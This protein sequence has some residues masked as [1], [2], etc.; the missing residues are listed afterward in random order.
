MSTVPLG[1]K[2]FFAAVGALALWVAV[3]GLLLPGQVTEALPWPVPPL[4]ARFLGSMY[5]SGA[6]FMVGALLARTWPTVRVIV[7]MISVWT[8]ALAIVSLV[9]LA[10]FDFGR[11][12]T[13]VWFAAYLVYPLIAAWIA[14]R[15]RG[16]HE[17]S[18]GAA[19]P[20]LLRGYLLAQGGVLVLLALGLF[21]FPDAAAGAW[22]W[23]ITPL[24]A[25]IYGAPFLSYG[26]GSLCA[27]RQ[28]TRPEVRLFLVG[29]LVFAAG[30]Q[31][32][33]GLHRALFSSTSPA[34]WIWFVG[35]A[36]MAVALAA[37]LFLTFAANKGRR[38]SRC[39]CS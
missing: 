10:E 39:G 19:I 38:L 37:A 16:N 24:L 23:P 9:H 12:Q 3:F 34:A 35:F 20:G 4:H 11:T 13:W 14:W 29:T 36:T 7:P 22:P 17:H 21:L 31:V 30:V 18:P 15:M 8:G 6:T 26:L 32:S 5:L 25:Q 2:L 28:E 33:S 27:A 1:D